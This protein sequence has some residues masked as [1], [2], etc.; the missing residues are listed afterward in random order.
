MFILLAR[1]P[2]SYAESD[3]Y[4]RQILTYKDGPRAERVDRIKTIDTAKEL[5]LFYPVLYV[6]AELQTYSI[7]PK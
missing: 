3:V 7:W 1:G 2:S 6:R 5:G 4:R